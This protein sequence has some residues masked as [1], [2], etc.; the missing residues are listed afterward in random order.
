MKKN[1]LLVCLLALPFFLS[2]QTRA[3]DSLQALLQQHSQPD[4]ARLHL[5]NELAKE[6]RDE[7][8]KRSQVRV[9]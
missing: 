4:T 1:L 2:A 8:V 5:L 6:I 7:D 3:P 9:G